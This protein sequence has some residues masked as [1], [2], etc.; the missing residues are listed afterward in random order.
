VRRAAS[1][2]T[3]LAAT[4]GVLAVPVLARPVAQAHAVTPH[5]ASIAVQPRPAI[6]GTLGISTH[7]QT[8]RFDLVGA[9]WRRGT[10][11][12]GAASIQVRV[13]A[14]DRW[15]GW[16]SLSATDGGADGGTADARRARMVNGDTTT[17][18][19]V[20]VG[21]ADGVQARVV[22][23]GQVPTDLHV[24]LVDGGTS[25]ADAD[26]QPVRVWGGSVAD[27]AVNQPAIY[28]RA[29]WGADESLR[30]QAC[31]SGPSYSPTIKMG[32]VHHTDSGNGYSRSQVPSII[33]SIYAYHVRA[34]GWCDIGYNYLVDRFG[35]IWEGRA[36]GITKPVLGAHTGGFNYDSFG[37]SLIGSYDKTKPSAAMLTALEKLFA[38][39]LAGY[40][41]DPSGKATLVADSFSGSRYRAGTTVTFK[42]ISGHRN[43]DLTTCPGTYAY[44]DLP[45]MRTATRGVMGAGF[46]APSATTDTAQM[47]NGAVTVNAG[48]IA[49]QSWTL[50]VTDAAGATVRTITGSADRHT[51]VAARWDLT[52]DIGA[53]V[54][55]GAYTLTLTGADAGGDQAVPWTTAMSVTPPV[56]LSA[57]SQTTLDAPVIVNGHGIPGHTVDVTVATAAGPQTVGSFR[58]TPHGRWSAGT[59]AVTADR[60]LAF[61]ATDPAITGYSKTKTAAVGPAVTSPT[62]DP[63]FVPTGGPLTVTGTDLPGADATVHLVT[64]PASGGQSATGSPLAVAA[65]GTWTTAFTPTV[66][67]SYTVVDGRGL[68]TAPRLVYPVAPASASA[69]SAGY[70]GRAVTVTGNAGGAPVR[71]TLSA[72]Q[73]SGAWSAVKSVTSRPS[74]RYTLELPLANSPGQQTNWRVATSYGPSVSG[75]VAIQPVFAPTVTGPRRSAW[76]SQHRLAGTAVPGDVV[77]VWTAR[78][79]ATADSTRW[80]KRGTVTAA[81]DD[82]WSLSLRINRDTAWRVSSPSGTS[83]I[84][85][86]VVAPTIHAPAHVVARAL[87]VISGR[88]IPGQ[89]VTVYRRVSGSTTWTVDTTQTAAADGTWSV[90]RHPRRSVDYRAVSHQQTSRTVSVAVD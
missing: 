40:Y 35:R 53:P 63:A 62:V 29:D 10:L 87:A 20:Y 25:T 69:P 7:P 32:F 13:H 44:A 56:T 2:F 1:A 82:T 9:T 89:T 28:S 80:V 79:G 60:D 39:R 5:V 58:V 59:A 19:P 6:R 14:G 17:A 33:R 90:G 61:T 27:A 22:G 31:P 76:H 36:G 15:S 72:R 83:T 49:A 51:D 43:A 45:D 52:D 42:M 64:T 88:A 78:A 50:T 47:A 23:A 84:G 21:G 67:T 16:R 57:P 74:G 12:S 77:T 46:V 37:A 38:W 18:E 30:K 86:T 75:T 71:V 41:L 55:P 8:H 81:A 54:L 11:D 4:A 66:P 24:L 70:A 85:T 3:V 68:A 48:A 34:N 26:P 73:P 65:D